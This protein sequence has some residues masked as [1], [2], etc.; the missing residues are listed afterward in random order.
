MPHPVNIRESD[1]DLYCGRGPNGNVANVGER[2]WLGNPIKKN[3]RCPVCGDVHSGHGS[4]LE[5]YEAYLRHRLDTDDR[6]QEAFLSEID[7]D[8]RLGCFCYPDP[9]HTEVIANV[10]REF[11][12]MT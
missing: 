2:G 3:Q 11:T 6:F 8:T 1:C 7:E 4:T 12:L 5:C 9:C 10:W